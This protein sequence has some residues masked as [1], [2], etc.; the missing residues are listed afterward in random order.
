MRHDVQEF[1]GTGVDVDRFRV[2][3]VARANLLW[4]EGAR[5]SIGASYLRAVR[6]EVAGAEGGAQVFPIPDRQ[7]Q[8]RLAAIAIVAVAFVI[9]RIRR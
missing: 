3:P 4:H 9:G 7:M 5:W 2:Q 8:V 1:V 6:I